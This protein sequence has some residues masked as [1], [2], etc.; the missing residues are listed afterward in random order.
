MPRIARAG[1]V[2]VEVDVTNV[3]QRAGDEV[4]QLYV[5][6]QVA[7]VT[8]PVKELKG[9][10]RVTLAPGERKTV[11]FS[12]GPAAFR[13]WDIDMKEVVEPGLFDIM[14]GPSSAHLKSVT[15]EIV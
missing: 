8:R 5:H 2:D 15:L 4:V 11:R 14:A 10:R 3:G 9:F 1:T 13:M 6:D 7:S 12:L